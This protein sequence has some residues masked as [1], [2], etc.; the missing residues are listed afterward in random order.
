[1]K[2][3]IVK[4]VSDLHI[5]SANGKNYDCKCRGRFRKEKL[6]PLVGDYVL[7]DQ[8]QKVIEEI[9]PRKN[10]FHRPKVANIDQTILVTS[11]KTPN[12]SLNLLDQLIVLM[13]LHHVC[14][15]ICITKSDL[16]DTPELESIKKILSYYEKLG[17]MVVFNTELEKI[18]QLLEGKTTV[19]TGQ[20]GAGKSTLL[21]KIHE[22]LNLE[23]GEVSLALGRG[24]HTTR[25]VELFP[26]RN[27][28]ILDTPGFSLLDFSSYSDIEIRD[29]FIEFQNYPCLYQ[30]CMH[31]KEGECCVKQ[32]VFSNHIMKSRYDN[33]LKFIDRK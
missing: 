23:V 32:A 14:P 20:T 6:L 10:E 29:S 17:Y 13:E 15:I 28:K 4:I 26:Y 25:V 8:D 22:G 12:F 31:K 9:L 2:G 1:M 16:V 30:D 19:F 18:R 7:F 21:N 24:R 27:G 33:Y 5:V 11:L 3:Q